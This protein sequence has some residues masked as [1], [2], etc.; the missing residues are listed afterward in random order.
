MDKM[1]LYFLIFSFSGWFMEVLFKFIQYGKLVNRGFLVGPICPIYGVCGVTFYYIFSNIS[2]NPFI[3]FAISFLFC[4]VIEYLTSYVLELLF[5][6]RWWDYSHK[7]FNINGRICL[8]NLF[9]F[10][11]MGIFCVYFYD[12]FVFYL[13]D[14]IPTNLIS[15][16]TVV[17]FV[18]LLIDIFMSIEMV[19]KLHDF[20]SNVKHDATEEISKRI[21]KNLVAKSFYF[22]RVIFAYPNFMISSDYI[23]TLKNKIRNYSANKKNKS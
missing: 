22:K 14:L 3:V 1:F 8:R 13:I 5:H 10:G 20:I 19:N 11:I 7:K 18:L 12:S 4:A 2:Y 17:L 6:A 23:S 15:I 9:F 21:R 16:I